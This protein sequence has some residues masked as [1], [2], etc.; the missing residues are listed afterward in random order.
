MK[1]YVFPSVRIVD[2]GEQVF[3]LDRLG[4]ISF[5]L[6]LEGDGP[7]A[8]DGD[9]STSGPGKLFLS[10]T[11]G[12]WKIASRANDKGPPT[13]VLVLTHGRHWVAE[14]ELPSWFPRNVAGE[15]HGLADGE[16][17]QYEL[18]WELVHKFI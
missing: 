18:Y 4:G 17:R 7:S 13:R 15:F 6:T 9:W 1:L 16:V 8:E 5:Q 10:E 11:D 14:L 2:R 12:D 3:G